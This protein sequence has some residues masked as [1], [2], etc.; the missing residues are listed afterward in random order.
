MGKEQTQWQSDQFQ[1]GSL[2]P[3]DPE[4]RRRM[5]WE[6]RVLSESVSYSFARWEE[7]GKPLP[8]I[9]LRNESGR[10]WKILQDLYELQRRCWNRDWDKIDEKDP[11]VRLQIATH[12]QEYYSAKSS[13]LKGLAQ[14]IKKEKRFHLFH[15][16]LS[17]SFKIGSMQ[18]VP[19]IVPPL[20][21]LDVD[22]LYLLICQKNRFLVGT[23]DGIFWKNVEWSEEKLKDNSVIRI[24][25]PYIF[26]L[27]FIGEKELVTVPEKIIHT[28]DA[29]KIQLPKP[30]RST[31]DLLEE[32]YYHQ[33]FIVPLDGAEVRF[34]KAGDLEKMIIIQ[35]GD[36]LLARVITRFGEGFLVLNIDTLQQLSG[37]ELIR[38]IELTPGKE[39]AWINILAEVYHD[40]VTAMELP[41]R[42]YRVL[43]GSKERSG[44]DKPE[45]PQVI[46]IPRTIRTKE[47]VRLPYKGLPRP[48]TPHRVI[49]H[50]RRGNMTEQHREV[51]M[52]FE[53]EYGLSIIANLPA[54]Y[55]FVRP[56]VVPAGTSEEFKNLPTF[57]KRRIQKKLNQELTKRDLPIIGELLDRFFKK[58]NATDS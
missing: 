13:Y 24:A 44:V 12:I 32:A 17:A 14:E 53:K 50:R 29:E 4:K 26:S 47:V 38:G 52:G 39:S 36:D 21:A 16:L 18:E 25:L 28:K 2:L 48:L 40:L 57:I 34:Q 23:R 5:P 56:Y 41:W 58:D 46:Y 54:G 19:E 1:G 30:A 22:S 35:S 55:T 7:F 27:D 43:G 20:L 11:A 10:E 49:G 15:Q 3:D 37:P 6:E 33:R 45:R 42:H 51:L 31:E 9:N 8:S